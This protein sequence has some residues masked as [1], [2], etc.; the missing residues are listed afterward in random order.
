MQKIIGWLMLAVMLGCT[1]TSGR[2]TASVSREY[3]L[4]ENAQVSLTLN[5]DGSFRYR[6]RSSI[7]S[8]RC[9][10]K[11]TEIILN[12]GGGAFGDF[13]VVVTVSDHKIRFPTDL[14]DMFH[15]VRGKEL[16]RR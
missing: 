5:S 6:V 15:E 4:P 9:D 16:V 2:S 10:V 12:F 7:L 3:V 13:G 1:G 11:G 14:G 8:G